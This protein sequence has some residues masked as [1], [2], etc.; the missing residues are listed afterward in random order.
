MPSAEG[1][2]RENQP[3]NTGRYV[4]T[5]CSP[6]KKRGNA[7]GRGEG[8][9]EL[10]QGRQ[11]GVVRKMGGVMGKGLVGHITVAG[12]KRHSLLLC[13]GRIFPKIRLKIHCRQ[14]LPDNSISI[15]EKKQWLHDVEPQ[16]DGNDIPRQDKFSLG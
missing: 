12:Y 13:P 14:R 8:N 1:T 15:S 3:I 4:I 11:A 2:L 6:K 7:D 9:D 5:V 10:A 16:S